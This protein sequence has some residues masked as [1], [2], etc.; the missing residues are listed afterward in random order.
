MDENNFGL[1]KGQRIYENY[2]GKWVSLDTMNNGSSAGKLQGIQDEFMQLFPYQGFN[3]RENG[4]LEIKII[5]NGLPKVVY[6][7]VI[8]AITPISKKSLENYCKKKTLDSEKEI[9][10]TKKK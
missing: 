2:I 8:T 5:K 1:T 7:G 4:V 10:K 6:T 3:W 9:N